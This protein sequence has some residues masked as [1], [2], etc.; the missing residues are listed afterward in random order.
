MRKRE[1]PNRTGHFEVH[2]VVREP[3]YGRATDR[4]VRRNVWNWG[5][6]MRPAGDESKRV[7]DGFQELAAQA[8]PLLLVPCGCLLEFGG[9]FA[10][11]AE[12]KGHRCVRRRATR[13]RTSSHGSP[14]DSLARARRPR[15]SISFAHAA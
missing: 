14:E 11:S 7:I 6:R 4:Q 5:S 9:G 3:P 1:D 12:R 8:E 13:S 2:D 10:L 15:L